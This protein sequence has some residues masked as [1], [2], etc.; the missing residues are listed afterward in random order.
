[1]IKMKQFDIYQSPEIEVIELGVSDIL[2]DSI[3]DLPVVGD[4]W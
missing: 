4:D 2:T 3:G 1:M